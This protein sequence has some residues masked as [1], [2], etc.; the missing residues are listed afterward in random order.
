[1]IKCDTT[2]GSFRIF[3]RPDWSPIG[4]ARLKSL[5]ENKWFDGVTFNRVSTHF[6]VQFGIRPGGLNPAIPVPSSILDDPPRPDIPFTNGIVSFAGS[7]RNSRGTEIFITYGTQK[8]LGKRSWETPIGF[9]E[10]K[11]MNTVINKL[12]SKYGDMPPWGNGPLPHKMHA[13]YGQEWLDQNY[14]L[15]T[16][17]ISCRVHKDEGGLRKIGLQNGRISSRG[18]TFRLKPYISTVVKEKSYFF[19]IVCFFLI[20]FSCFVGW[21]C[22]SKEKVKKKKTGRG[23]Q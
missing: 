23:E 1:M 13:Q 8:G 12:Y 4:A 2:A 18:S 17:I 10:E 14:P 16:K 11:D 21:K 6:L 7:G 3:L 20:L 9:V 15:L 5:V 19:T 22:W